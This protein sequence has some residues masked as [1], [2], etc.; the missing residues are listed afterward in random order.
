MSATGIDVGDAVMNFLADT[1]ELD[2]AFA[3]IDATPERLQPPKAAVADLS[4]TLQGMGTYWGQ[5]GEE[6]IVAGEEMSAAAKQAEFDMHEAKGEIALLGEEIGVKVPRHVRGFL[7]ELPGVGAALNAAFTATAVLVLIQV[8]V[9]GTKKLTEFVSEHFIFTEA[10]KEVEKQVAAAN[11][12]LLAN[13]KAYDDAHEALRVWGFSAQ[14]LADDAVN[15]LTKKITENETAMRNAQNTLYFYRNGLGGTA[16]EAAKAGTQLQ[17]LSTSLNAQRE[18]LTALQL[19]QQKVALADYVKHQ[20]DLIAAAKEKGEFRAKISLD[21]E[22]VIQAGIRNSFT[23][24]RA[25]HEQFEETIYRIQREA[26]QKRLTLLQQQ[27]QE[28]KEQQAQVN[29]QIE[30]LEHQHTERLAQNYVDFKQKLASL[31]TIPIPLIDSPIP[32]EIK[33]QSLQDLADLRAAAELIGIP[34]STDLFK[35][36]QDAGH[37]YNL[38]RASGLASTGDLLRAQLALTQATIAYKQDIGESTVAEEK[39]LNKLQDAYD[40]LTGRID[41]THKATRDFFA[42]F[43]I[44]MKHGI[45]GME[46]VK[47][48]GSQ[49]FNQL[50]AGISSAVATAILA[51]GNLGQ[52]LKQATADAL[53]AIAG[54]A[55]VKAIFYTAEGFAALAGFSEYSASQ[56]FAAAGEMALV[57]GVAAIAGRALSSSAQ[58]SPGAGA[59][60]GGAGGSDKP[61]ATAPAQP[62][63]TRNVQHFAGGGLVTGPTMAVIG[64]STRGTGQNEAAIPLDD[65]VAVRK[66]VEALGGGGPAI[67]VHVKGMVSPDNLKKVVKDINRKVNRGQVNLVSSNSLRITKRSQ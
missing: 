60:T 41:K 9:E 5:A 20:E 56:Y 54:Q 32:A 66:I 59:G 31:R 19:A 21:G 17:E 15:Q 13:K 48:I 65:P 39:N 63:S 37:A 47:D 50:A 51:Q 45:S 52:A 43:Q 23:A 30:Q 8:L 14:Q 49:S 42:Q 27:G 25:A 55:I 3:K 35:A 67:H 12:V 36:A 7:A 57:G 34:L 22:L 4:N 62:V 46:Q 53:A 16:E 40:K 33:I 64:D 61:L 28:T 11:L 24:Q 18:Q 58:T 10:L 26:L 2:L 1:T 6:A 29:L 44:D 38:L